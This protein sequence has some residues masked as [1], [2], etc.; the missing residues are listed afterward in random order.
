MF[1]RVRPKG[2]SMI[3]PVTE[4]NIEEAAFVHSVSWRESHR[5]FCDPA[6]MERH[7]PAHQKEYIQKKMDAG[8]AFYLLKEN[9]PVGVVSVN[10]S[11]IED[12]YVL[13]TEQKRGYGAK[14]LALAMKKCDGTPTLW[15]LEN[16]S[17]AETFYRNRGFKP[18][19]RRNHIAGKLDEIEFS[20]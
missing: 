14:L 18:T 5:S 11:L 19:G 13:P 15:I 3:V 17:N 4:A 8:S 7:D 12:L 1:R 20:L 10:G 16:N 9:G 6:F 2:Y